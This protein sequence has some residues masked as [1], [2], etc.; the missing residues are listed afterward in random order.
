MR[1]W[2]P[3]LVA[4]S[5]GYNRSQ[6][7]FRLLSGIHRASGMKSNRMIN[8]TMVEAD[9]ITGGSGESPLV[10]FSVI[11]GL[12]PSYASDQDWNP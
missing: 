6:V 2:P 12:L 11:S 10:E 5:L 1:M 3:R 8:P 9:K 4:N 7:Q